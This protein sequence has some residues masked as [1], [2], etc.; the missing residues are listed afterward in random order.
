MKVDERPDD[1]EVEGQQDDEG[2]DDERP[3]RLDLLRLGLDADRREGR[4][5]HAL[6]VFLWVFA[7]FPC[8]LDRDYSELAGIL[9][10]FKDVDALLGE[11]LS[12]HPHRLLPALY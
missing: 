8:A 2:T 6:D 10:V 1:A 12:P 7:F 9:G 3:V 5:G 4:A 11:L